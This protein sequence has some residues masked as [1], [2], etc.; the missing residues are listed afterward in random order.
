MKNSEELYE[1]HWG[2]SDIIL[3]L[4]IYTVILFLG[5]YWGSADEETV[6]NDT[7]RVLLVD[8]QKREELKSI[9]DNGQN[10]RFDFKEKKFI[11]TTDIDYDKLELWKLR[12]KD[13]VIQKVEG[14]YEI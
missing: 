13:L 3:K 12:S 8:E 6:S 4:I 2:C 9:Y 1:R 5:Y 7:M 10:A 11:A 14:D